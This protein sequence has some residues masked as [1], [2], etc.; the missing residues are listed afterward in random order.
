MPKGTPGRSKARP[1]PR[2]TGKRKAQAPLATA[3][4]GFRKRT[5][6]ARQLVASTA[7]LAP[8]LGTMYRIWLKHEI[9]PGFRE[10]LM[11]AVS[12]LN[13][14][15]YCTWGH[16]EWAHISGVSDEELAHLEQW[17]PSGFDRRKWLAIT[18]VRALVTAEFKRTP[19]ELRREMK[20]HYSPRKIR[21]IELIA[22]VMD[23]ANRGSNTWD[24]MLSR[25]RG[26][27]AADSRILDE[28]VLSALF[29][30]AAPV[31]VLFLARASQRPFM[32]MARSLVD[33]TTHYADKQS[34]AGH[35][36]RS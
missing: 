6:T 18:Y 26:T 20:A 15:R 4:G 16:H 9:D 25:L 13:D 5:I 3:F 19:A 24:A 34:V 14:C 8:E 22:R 33:Y 17:D 11:V 36:R 29:L 12:R 28:L 27:P 21:E 23:I 31:V 7:S 2:N 10:E 1:A 32:E 35:A 30:T